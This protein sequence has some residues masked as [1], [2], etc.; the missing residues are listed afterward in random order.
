MG[1]LFFAGQP[2]DLATCTSFTSTIVGDGRTGGICLTLL[3]LHF[4]GSVSILISRKRL[5]LPKVGICL[6][7]TVSTI[8][9]ETQ[10]LS[11]LQFLCILKS[12]SHIV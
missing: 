6:L 2:N 7:A 9:G 1:L 8:Q 5:V 11:K 12:P 10:G 4:G 3:L